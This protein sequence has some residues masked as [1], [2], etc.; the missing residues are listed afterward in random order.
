[1]RCLS[2]QLLN[3]CACAAAFKVPCASANVELSETVCMYLLNRATV[4]CQCGDELLPVQGSTIRAFY[5]PASVTDDFRHLA[6]G[7]NVGRC[8]VKVC[9]RCGMPL[10]KFVLEN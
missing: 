8:G 9:L 6:A 1:M 4:R 5:H 2:I 10:S 7:S 3:R